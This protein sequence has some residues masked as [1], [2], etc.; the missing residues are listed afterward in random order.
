M[1]PIA[2]KT[3]SIAFGD[4]FCFYGISQSD[5]TLQFARKSKRCLQKKSELRVLN[6]CSV[7]GLA[8]K[9]PKKSTQAYSSLLFRMHKRIKPWQFA[10]KSK[11]CLQKKSE[12]RVFN[13]IRRAVSNKELSLHRLSCW[14]V[15][16]KEEQKPSNDEQGHQRIE[17]PADEGN[18]GKGDGHQKLHQDHKQAQSDGGGAHHDQLPAV[19]IVKQGG[20]C[21]NDQTHASCH[22]KGKGQEPISARHAVDVKQIEDGGGKAAGHEDHGIGLFEPGG[23][24]DRHVK[25]EKGTHHVARPGHPAVKAQIAKEDDEQGQKDCR[26]Q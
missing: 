6:P 24:N 16:P 21:R 15:T 12:L 14:A 5:Q 11:R 20:H 9:S 8:S 17:G 19:Q 1:Q 10:R 26:R 7:H 2:I 3:K 18:G 25:E 4:G 23:Q 13:E 22:G